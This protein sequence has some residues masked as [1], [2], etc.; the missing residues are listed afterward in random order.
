[1]LSNTQNSET[2]YRKTSMSLE[3]KL[4][5]KLDSYADRKFKGNRSA[6][7]NYLLSAL[8]PAQELEIVR[9]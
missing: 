1:M 5:Q 6:A 4:V 9:Y 7:V 2:K 8:A 3:S